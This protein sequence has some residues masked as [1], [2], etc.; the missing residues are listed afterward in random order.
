M[1]PHQPLVNIT[2]FPDA[3]EPLKKPI[4]STKW[5]GHDLGFSC[6]FRQW[7]AE[8]HC[9]LLHGYGLAFGFE[10]EATELDER[11]WVVDFGGLKEL[12]QLLADTFDHKTLVA[13]DDPQ[14]STFKA[15]CDSGVI[16]MI[17]VPATGCEAFARMV[18][19]VTE[20]WLKDAGYGPRCKLRCVEVAEHGANSVKCFG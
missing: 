9:R 15:L 16:D 8:S 13:M 2:D 19:D 4:V 1:H 6:C 12:K 3:L 10:F 5:F 7:R 11:G 14:L 20:Q 18:F 17:I